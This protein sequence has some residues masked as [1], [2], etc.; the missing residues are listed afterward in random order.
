MRV[1]PPLLILAL[2]LST[3][4]SSWAFTQA[5][6]DQ[7]AL[8]ARQI[9]IISTIADD[10][11]LG[12]DNDTPESTA[13]QQV[14]IDELKLFADGLN[15][16]ETGDDAYK[17]A[18]STSVDGT[19]VLAVIP[20]TDPNEYVMVGAHYDHL[21]FSGP[22]IFNG[23]TDNAAG[24]AI[25]LAIGAAIDA[26]PGPPGR[27]VILALWDA[28]EDPVLVGS[29]EFFDSPLVPL[30]KII[31]YVNFDIQ[32]A[33]LLPSV[34]NLSF[35]IG[36]ES[37]GTAFETM[38]AGAVAQETID[39]RQLSRL[40]GQDRSD[41]ANFIDTI[42]SVFFSDATGPCYHT[43]GDDIT[44]VDFQKLREQS[45]IGF[46]LTVDLTE[47]STPPPFVPT[48]FLDGTYQDALVISDIINGAI[49]DL[50]LFSPTEQANLLTAQADVQAVVD[51]GEG[52]FDVTALTTVALAAIAALA[53]LAT[54][55]C[56]GFL[57]TQAVPALP[58]LAQLLLLLLLVASGSLALHRMTTKYS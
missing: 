55:E 49:V 6:I 20:G 58:P 50:D 42:P 54:L 21:G 9:D 56:D 38:V 41:H 1:H 26:L 47:T 43:P 33:N 30:S 28:E 11:Y 51:A 19:N 8:V 10:I 31:A 5:E 13:V 23:A 15:T 39:T 32:G 17:Q 14:L 57:A 12:R 35:S 45:Q 27:S 25:V 36:A 18:F 22:D 52:A 3:P 29:A 53:A 48:E 40:F 24:T 4:G 34:R 44:V 7:A 46:R 37:G 16:A 2:S